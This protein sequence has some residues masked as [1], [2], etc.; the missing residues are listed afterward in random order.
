M[1][2]ANGVEVSAAAAPAKRRRKAI[3]PKAAYARHALDPAASQAPFDPE[4]LV[5]RHSPP[6]ALRAELARRLRPHQREGGRFIWQRL[7]EAG[8]GAILADECGLGKTLTAIASLAALMGEGVTAP[9]YRSCRSV[10]VCP[11]TLV[12]QWAEEI[13]RWLPAPCGLTLF[14]VNQEPLAPRRAVYR[15]KGVAAPAR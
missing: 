5:L 14:V 7:G 1:R 11:A 2:R 9:K 13:R 4:D 8:R 15:P 10:I 3:D 12:N 6:V